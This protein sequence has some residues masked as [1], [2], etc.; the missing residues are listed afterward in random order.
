MKQRMLLC[1]SR[2]CLRMDGTRAGK[3]CS[4]RVVSHDSGCERSLRAAVLAFPAVLWWW[5]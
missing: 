1:R 5:W 2:F 3:I 4:L